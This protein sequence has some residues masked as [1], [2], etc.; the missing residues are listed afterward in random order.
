V[1]NAVTEA[2]KPLVIATGRKGASVKH[3]LR[4]QD[5][6]HWPEHQRQRERLRW[7]GPDERDC[8]GARWQPIHQPF[9]TERVAM[10]L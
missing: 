7:R 1:G 9:G 2:A 6:Q 4:Y 8:V 5:D 3:S 10:E